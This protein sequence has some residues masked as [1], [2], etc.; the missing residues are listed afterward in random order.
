MNNRRWRS[1]RA[2]LLT[3]ARMEQLAREQQFIDPPSQKVVYLDSKGGSLAQNNGA[4]EATY[5]Q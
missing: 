1:R 4:H 5:R 3:P 2:Q